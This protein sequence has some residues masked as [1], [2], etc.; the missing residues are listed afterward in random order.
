MAVGGQCFSSF[1]NT[2]VLL[3]QDVA[4]PFRPQKDSSFT[5]SIVWH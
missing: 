4:N 2:G 3:D 5:R 1:L